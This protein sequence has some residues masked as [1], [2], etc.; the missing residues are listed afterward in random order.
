MNQERTKPVVTVMSKLADLCVALGAIN[1]NRQAGT[2]SHQITDAWS[3]ELNPHD[4]Q[5]DGIAPYTAVFSCHGLPTVLADPYGGVVM[6]GTLCGEDA[7]I[8]VLDAAIAQAEGGPN[9]V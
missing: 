8:E 2:W 9:H 6:P 7:L 5:V 3:V 4:I 1:L